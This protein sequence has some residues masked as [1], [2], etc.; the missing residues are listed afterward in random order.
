[1]EINQRYRLLRRTLA[2]FELKASSVKQ[3]SLDNHQSLA[4]LNDVLQQVD[5]EIN[6]V[7]CELS[8]RG[9]FESIDKYEY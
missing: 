9:N 2:L 5:E 7:K 3:Y 1:M 4:R 8:S 6:N